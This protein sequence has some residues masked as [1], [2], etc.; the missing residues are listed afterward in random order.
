VRSLKAQQLAGHLQVIVADDQSSDGTSQCATA[1]GADEVIQV[2]ER[3]VGWRGKLWAVESGI[4]ADTGNPDYFLLTDADIEY[5]SLDLLASLIAQAEHGFDLVSVMVQLRS[6]SLAEKMLI[7]AFTFFF[8]K[9]YPPQWVASDGGTAAAAG[10][11]MLIRREFL[12]QMGGIETIHSALIDDCA[13]ARQIRLIHLEM[14]T[15]HASNELRLRYYDLNCR[16][17]RCS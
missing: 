8:F 14:Q 10:G 15:L 17:H 1:A 5:K 6:K 7:P 12:L 3:P 16:L 4:C 11:C 2:K 13:L 9:L